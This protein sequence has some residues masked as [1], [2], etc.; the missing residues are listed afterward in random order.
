MIK[1]IT[2]RSKNNSIFHGESMKD[3]EKSVSFG[4]SFISVLFLSGLSGYYFGKIIMDWSDIKVYLYLN[5]LN[6]L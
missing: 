2:A 4:V 6:S 5:I 1:D 3:I